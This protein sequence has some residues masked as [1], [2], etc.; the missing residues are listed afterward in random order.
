MHRRE[1]HVSVNSLLDAMDNAGWNAAAPAKTKTPP[2]NTDK[3]KIEQAEKIGAGALTPMQFE[4]VTGLPGK[5]LDLKLEQ[6]V[7]Q[8]GNIQGIKAWAEQLDKMMSA[9]KK[10]VDVRKMRSELIAFDFVRAHVM[11]YLN[12]LSEQLFDYAGEDKKMLKAITKI[13]KD[14]Q[15]IIDKEFHKLQRYQEIVAS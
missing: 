10:S 6:M 14:T 1:G 3:A 9:L 15:K 11:T 12:V 4:D 7:L 2:G 13:I 5:F 8:H